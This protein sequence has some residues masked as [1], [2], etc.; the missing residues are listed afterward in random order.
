[1]SDRVKLVAEITNQGLDIVTNIYLYEA[2]N[3]PTLSD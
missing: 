1:M 2:R 3:D